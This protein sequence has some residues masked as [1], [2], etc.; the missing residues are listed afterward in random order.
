[1]SLLP[2]SQEKEHK[3]G[4]KNFLRKLTT[5]RNGPIKSTE[6]RKGM[7]TQEDYPATEKLW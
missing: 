3:L 4:V 2:R 6:T 7:K 5:S 1:M